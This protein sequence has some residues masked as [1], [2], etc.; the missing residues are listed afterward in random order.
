MAQTP[1]A[2]PEV[3]LANAERCQR[4]TINVTNLKQIA[5][6][7]NQKIFVIAHLGTGEKSSNLNR[8]RLKDVGAEFDQG[9]PMSRE[10][11]ILAEGERVKGLARIDVYIGSKLQFISYIPRNGDFCS[12]CCNRR[13]EFYK[14]WNRRRTR[15]K[16]R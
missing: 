5:R 8:R 3:I 10:N 4:N 16:S 12:L 15:K 7:E 13:E 14:N 2:E 1:S 11:L 6:L 9:G